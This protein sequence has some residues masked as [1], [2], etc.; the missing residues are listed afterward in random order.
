MTEKFDN[1][2]KF[3]LEASILDLPEN[4]P[5]GFWIDASG[6]ILPVNYEAHAQVARR[7]IDKN[8]SYKKEFDK[9]ISGFTDRSAVDLLAIGYLLN[10]KWVKCVVT[11]YDMPTLYYKSKD[12][13]T[14]KQKHAI[15]D[16]EMRYDIY[17]NRDRD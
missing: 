14:P 17:V 8:E 1:F 13:L 6:D 2:I 7:V 12:I 11:R 16:L 4:C 5:Y 9:S 10:H 15:N 3:L